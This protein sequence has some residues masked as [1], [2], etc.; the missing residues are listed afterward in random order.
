MT[1]TAIPGRRRPGAR[2]PL[3]LE[4]HLLVNTRTWVNLAFELFEPLLYLLAIGFGLG[5]VIGSVAGP[6]VPYAAYVAPGLLA[7]AAMNGA[8]GETTFRVFL[9]IRHERF[10]D[11]ILVTPLSVADVAIG[12]V[13]WAMLRAVVAATGFLAASTVLGLLRSPW[14]LLAVP[15]AALIG[16]AFGSTGLYAT[17]Y[18]RN[19]Q[20]FQYIQLVMLPMFMFATTFYPLSVYPAGL[21]P[22]IAMLPLYQAIE[23]VRGVALGS[24]GPGLLVAV[25]YLA[26]LGVVTLSLAVGRLRRQLRP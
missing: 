17:T 15:A 25:A 12:E 3:L 8:F 5:T 18:L 4:R 10:Y 19:W 23:L 13:A 16:F 14:A 21:R 24:F 7:A 1:T 26:G 9:R 2:A 20:D 6:G 11:S 22:V